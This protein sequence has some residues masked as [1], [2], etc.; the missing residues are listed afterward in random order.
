MKNNVTQYCVLISGPSDTKLEIGIAKKCIDKFNREAGATN[1]INLLTQHWEDD[2]YPELGD[3]PQNILNKQIV[4][5]CDAI[6]AIFSKRFGTPTENYGSGT[7]EEIDII[8]KKGGKVFLYFSDETNK[9]N[10]DQDQLEKLTKFKKSLDSQGLY[11][12]FQNA[13]DFEEKLLKH[14][15]KIFTDEK[16]L[17][18]NIEQE[19]LS[20][21][22][23]DFDGI[24]SNKY[25][26]S[27][28]R[29]TLGDSYIDFCRTMLTRDYRP[30]YENERSIYSIEGYD[31]GLASMCQGILEFNNRGDIYVAFLD[32]SRIKYFT[33]D[34]DY[35]DKIPQHKA[36]QA[37]LQKKRFKQFVYFCSSPPEKLQAVDG[38]YIRESSIGSEAIVEIHVGNQSVEFKYSAYSGANM[39]RPFTKTI[40]LIDGYLARYEDKKGNMLEFTFFDDT[41]CIKEKGQFGGLNVTLAGLYH[42]EEQ[43]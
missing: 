4:K 22:K 14:L 38:T 27:T 1:N 21:L 13:Q 37:W 7:E 24:L 8:R 28:I 33:N 35:I 11:A 6:I 36:M 5:S 15:N 23:I 17:A 20:Y 9:L 43:S 42:R 40:E 39:V 26:D 30:N 12:T 19:Y 34:D 31:P 18:K 29:Q 3:T 32:D 10:I 2:A 41:I 25:M 16:L